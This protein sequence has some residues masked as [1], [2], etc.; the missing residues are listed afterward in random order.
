MYLLKKMNKKTIDSPKEFIGMLV[1]FMY[2]IRFR[3]AYFYTFKFYA[4][5]YHN[6]NNCLKNVYN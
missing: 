4:T 1:V 6:I 5:F 2:I 3:P